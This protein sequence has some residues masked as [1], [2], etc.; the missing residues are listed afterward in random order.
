MNR[1]LVFCMGKRSWKM[2]ILLSIP[3]A[4]SLVL[5]VIEIQSVRE[6][7]NGLF[8]VDLDF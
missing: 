3:L 6:A 2:G 4:A 8:H 7:R 5:I 1:I